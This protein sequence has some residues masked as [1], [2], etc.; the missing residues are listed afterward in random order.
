M[1]RETTARIVNPELF[2]P[3]QAQVGWDDQGLSEQ[4]AQPSTAAFMLEVVK[5]RGKQSQ[6]YFT[7]ITHHQV[8]SLSS[9]HT[10]LNSLRRVTQIHCVPGGIC[11]M[12]KKNEQLTRN[13]QRMSQVVPAH[14]AD[15]GTQ[16][17]GAHS[18]HQTTP[19]AALS[20]CLLLPAF[21]RGFP[22]PG[23][24]GCWVCPQLGPHRIPLCGTKW[25]GHIWL[26]WN[27]PEILGGVTALR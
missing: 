7:I 4:Q 23:V 21:P 2:A 5:R 26:T 20:N 27:T 10:S 3:L 22:L 12:L 24:Q 9:F 14:G 19:N 18:S 6:I 15:V 25:M 13:Q 17:P 8:L 11:T 16:T 1:H